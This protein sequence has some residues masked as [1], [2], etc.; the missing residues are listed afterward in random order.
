[1]VYHGID[2]RHEELRALL[3]HKDGTI[4]RGAAIALTTLGT[5]DPNRD[6]RQ[7]VT[8]I[9]QADETDDSGSEP[10]FKWRQP[11]DKDAIPVL[12]EMLKDREP[13]NEELSSTAI[14]LYC[15]ATFKTDAA[16]AVPE[17]TKL[18]ADKDPILRQYAVK[19]L[20]AIA[21]AAEETRA[22]A[23]AALKD[24]D[25]QVRAA[26]AETLGQLGDRASLP[27]LK[28]LMK[29]ADPGVRQGV[30]QAFGCFK[31]DAETL[32][33][34]LIEVLKTPDSRL[35]MPALGPDGKQLP[36]TNNYREIN[37]VES[38]YSALAKFGPAAKP[39]VPELVKLASRSEGA[40][41][42]QSA[43]RALKKIAPDEFKKLKPT[44]PTTPAGLG[45]AG[46]GE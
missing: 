9:S 10:Q 44:T 3:G 16:A 18:L 23:R 32:V 24:A 29:D 12:I 43:R 27:A 46:R 19:V 35:R 13:L 4:R 28:A 30:V 37:V 42:T 36:E 40:M 8:R 15:L 21:P 17:V 41:F 26:G 31:D 5:I 38:A 39:A 20:E 14:S 33:P 34:I 22:A 1:M 2:P 11:G 6:P 25:A 45:A 7:A